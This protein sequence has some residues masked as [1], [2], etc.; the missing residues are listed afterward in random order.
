MTSDYVPID[1]DQHS[2]LELLAMRRTPVV[3]R[4]GGEGDE[5]AS[6][7]RGE[8]RD[9]LTRDGA[10]HLELCDRHGNVT[11]VR[12]DRLRSLSAPDGGVLWGQKSDAG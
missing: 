6:S 8:V 5:G 9:V 10:E 2:V 7:A 12:L 4:F 11:S 3:A 1:C